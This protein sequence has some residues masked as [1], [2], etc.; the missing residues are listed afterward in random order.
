MTRPGIRRA[1]LL[2]TGLTAVS[3]LFGF[4][5][6]VVIAAVFGAGAALDAYLV[7]Q[8]LMNIVLGLIAYAM[9]RAA[10]PVT[11]RE[12][13]EEVDGCR[14][15]PGFD[16]AITVTMIVLGVGG[17]VMSI[18]AGPVT[19]VI[20]PGFDGA[21]AELAESLTRIVL[22]ATV[23]IAGT[24]LLAALSQSHGRVAWSALQGVPFNII[25]IG[26]AGLFGPTYGIAALAVGFVVGSGARL[27][28]QLPPLFSLG[29]RVRP[30]L[31]LR[32]PGFREM[33]RLMPPMLVGSAI[34]N[35]NTL[36]DRAV[37]ST[38]E[39]GAITALSYGWRL[40]NLPE[41]LIIASLLV[42]LY[43]ALSASSKNIVEIRRLVGRGLA[44][45]V[46]VLTPLCVVMIIA[47]Q[48]L[49]EVAFGRGAFTG[50][51]ITATATALAWYAP[52]LL[53]LG[54]RQVVVSTSYAIG[55][56]R[57][58]VVVAVIAMVINVVGD[59]LLAPLM[60]I[61]GIALATTASLVFAALANS[62]LLRRRHQGLDLGAAVALL[63]RALLLAAVAGAAGVGA[64]ALIDGQPAIIT[65]GVAA[66]VVCGVYLL[67]LI[68][69]R[70]PE[71]LLALDMVKSVVRKGRRG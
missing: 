1:A 69:L 21:Q 18:F 55:D 50:D 59:I 47:A 20:A 37:G 15:H 6:D 71:R 29:T 64:L 33:A 49:A 10:I 36:V 17:V 52:A 4:V 13:A 53:A 8:G 48:P 2:V 62:W 28:L 34:G 63:A 54:C 30:R 68:V 66:L 45:A 12:A 56:A 16:T 70:A 41:T 14:G 31:N 9:A 19:A 35:I 57:A 27:L 65:G 7:A 42:P 67:G 3:T 51:D 58:P 22:I 46:S 32:D 26:A 24:D 60:G 5:R 43:P 38:L 44:V 25:M 61:A 39:E 23:L 11:S 40:V